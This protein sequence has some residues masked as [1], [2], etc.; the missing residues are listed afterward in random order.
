MASQPS[1]HP[2]EF[3]GVLACCLELCARAGATSRLLAPLPALVDSRPG[4]SEDLELARRW[5]T[6]M[7]TLAADEEEIVWLG[8]L[9]LTAARRVLGADSVEADHMARLFAEAAERALAASL[10]SQK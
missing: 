3:L 6:A 5:G 2:G 10:L 4:D 1:M 8:G 7:A 9:W